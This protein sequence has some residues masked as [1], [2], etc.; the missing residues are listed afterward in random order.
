MGQM[1]RWVGCWCFFVLVGWMIGGWQTSIAAEPSPAGSE[2]ITASRDANLPKAPVERFESF[3]SDLKTS[4]SISLG[5]RQDSF[6]WSVAGNASGTNPNIISELEWSNIDAYQLRLCN[7]TQVGRW[8]YFRSQFNYARIDNGT[9]RD[10]DYRSDD[11]MG[12][13]SRSISESS[14]DQ[15][16]DLSFGAGYPFFLASGRWQIAPLIGLSVSKQN[17]RITNGYQVIGAGPPD[18]PYVGPLDSRL[19]STYRAK[20]IGPWIGCDLRYQFN[21]NRPGQRAM[22]LGGTLELHWADYSA[23]GNWNLRGDLQHPVSF[24]HQ[25][26]GFGIQ[27]GVEWLI[28]LSARWDLSLAADYLRWTTDEG[29]NT[30]YRA[31]GSQVSRLNE[32]EWESHS[33]MVG[34]TYHF[35]GSH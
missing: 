19:N 7:R 28:R 12:E 18:T 6:E 16:W 34:A 5:L 32:V 4:F 3:S 20:W 30:Q 22:E 13:Y 11:H 10:S 24:K 23:E 8:L 21:P 27:L 17:F 2:M 9:L 29:V 14:G 33:F 35:I 26:R 31:T 1:L 15:L 25:A